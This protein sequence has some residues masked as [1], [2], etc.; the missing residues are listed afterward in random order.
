MSKLDG[1]WRFTLVRPAGATAPSLSPPPAASAGSAAPAAA[2]GPLAA[3]DSQWPLTQIEYT[4]C[5]W[6]KGDCGGR[7]LETEAVAAAAGR[8]Q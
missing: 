2:A 6:P 3:D 4:F 7:P 5:M 8:A 1:S